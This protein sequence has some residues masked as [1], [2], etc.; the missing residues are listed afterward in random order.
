MKITLLAKSSSDPG[1]YY[2]VAFYQEDGRL[3]IWC[4]CQA[5]AYG[6]LCKH[7]RQLASGDKRM[8]HNEDQIEELEVVVEWVKQSPVAQLIADL[9]K[10]E[11]KVKVAQ[12]KV[13]DLKADLAANM[14]GR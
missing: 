12:K 13:K 9:E 3:P 6:Q 5:G 14:R 11:K 2:H 7:K 10:A 8:L 4:D 1:S